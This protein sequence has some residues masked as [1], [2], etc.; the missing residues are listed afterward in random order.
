MIKKFVP[1]LE[2]RMFFYENNPNGYASK[3]T[4]R[5]YIGNLTS[6]ELKHFKQLLQLT[7]YNRCNLNNII[8]KQGEFIWCELSTPNAQLKLKLVYSEGIE[9]FLTDYQFGMFYSNLDFN[10]LMEEANASTGE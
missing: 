3:A 9:K 5:G 2:N 10:G 4:F 7:R 6:S 1:K 8:E